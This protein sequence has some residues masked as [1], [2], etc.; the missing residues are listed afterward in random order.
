MLDSGQLYNRDRRSN[1]ASAR[2]R[3]YEPR[4]LAEILN[5]KR[6]S[7][8]NIE[9]GNQRPSLDT[10]Y[11]FCER[12]GLDHRHP[13]FSGRGDPARWPSVVVGGK[14]Q[15]VGAKTAIALERLRPSQS[16]RR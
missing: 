16:M 3:R 7:I 2:I 11:C 13:S 5:L 8:T 1:Q 4:D 9:R 15:E 12:F 10:L 6:T 14:A